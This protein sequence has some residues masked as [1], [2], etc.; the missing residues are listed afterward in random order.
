MNG[1]TAARTPAWAGALKSCVAYLQ[2]PLGVLA[3][4]GAPAPEV[5]L[6][7]EGPKGECVA[8]CELAWPEQKVV[9]LRPDQD[10]LAFIW[11][12]Y[13]WT[14]LQLRGEA[15]LTDGQELVPALAQALGVTLSKTEE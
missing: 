11:T 5:G 14:V 15:N 4:A 6:E 12:G 3:D 13:G 9:V 7:L 10:D 1:P 2:A 8:D